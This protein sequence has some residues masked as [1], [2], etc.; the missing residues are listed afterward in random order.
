MSNRSKSSYKVTAF[1]L[2]YI[3]VMPNIWARIDAAEDEKEVSRIMREARN[4]AEKY[5][6]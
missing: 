5:G 6:S 4:L 1:Q 3:R 2:G